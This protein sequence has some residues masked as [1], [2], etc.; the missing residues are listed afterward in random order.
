MTMTL[1]VDGKKIEVQNDI[2]VV[3]RD[4]PISGNFLEED[5][6]ADLQVVLNCEGI[7]L[8]VLSQEQETQT[9]YQFVDDL[10]ELCH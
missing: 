1:I 9:A 3:Y 5:K 6:K 8:D 4:V 7:V 10:V 2:R